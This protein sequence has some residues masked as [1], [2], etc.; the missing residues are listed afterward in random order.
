MLKAESTVYPMPC[1]LSN[2]QEL[3]MNKWRFR[4]CLKYDL[5][6][7]MQDGEENDKEEKKFWWS[8]DTDCC[9]RVISD[10]M[11]GY[12]E[13]M[14]M[15]LYPEQVV[16]KSDGIF[17]I[18]LG[19]SQSIM[20]Q[21]RSHNPNVTLKLPIEIVGFVW[22]ESSQNTTNHAKNTTNHTIPPK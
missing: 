1:P 9:T 3:L 17:T 11:K 7:K 14:V 15:D 12:L 5:I 8:V 19:L 6:S 20:V 2:E 22:S 13:N 16:I 21:E 10:E 4:H 18:K